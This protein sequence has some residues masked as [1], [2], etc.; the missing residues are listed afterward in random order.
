MAN[1]H[2]FGETILQPGPLKQ[3]TKRLGASENSNSQSINKIRQSNREGLRPQPGWGT[4]QAKR[5]G[6]LTDSI[7]LP[8]RVAGKFYRGCRSED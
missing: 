7:G 1:S 5:H 4:E 2:R 8:S 6:G 3:N